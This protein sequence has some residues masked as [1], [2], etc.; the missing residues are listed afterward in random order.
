MG[1]NELG[2]VPR[3]AFFRDS[4]EFGVHR[5]CFFE[6]RP[7][8]FMQLVDFIGFGSAVGYL[9]SYANCYEPLCCEEMA[10]IH[11]QRVPGD[12]VLES[13]RLTGV[14]TPLLA[15]MSALMFWRACSLSSACTAG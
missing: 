11:S 2:G 5:L 8:K 12:R 15:I 3:H 1:Y 6:P 7:G 4:A 9:N 13:Q 14:S 10:G